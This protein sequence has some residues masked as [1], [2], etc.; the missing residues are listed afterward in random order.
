MAL[1]V[2]RLISYSSQARLGTPFYYVFWIPY[3]RQCIDK[4]SKKSIERIFLGGMTLIDPILH[5]LFQVGSR[6]KVP[7]AFF[8]ETVK[9]TAIKLDAL[10]N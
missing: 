10:T 1:R 7:A 8:S 5:R 6:Y 2:V 3:D 4:V 9:A